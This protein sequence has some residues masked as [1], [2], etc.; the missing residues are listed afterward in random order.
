MSQELSALS[1]GLGY[2]NIQRAHVMQHRFL[3]ICEKE[4][5]N[6]CP[7]ASA[8]NNITPLPAVQRVALAWRSTGVQ[9]FAC[10]LLCLLFLLVASALLPPNAPFEIQIQLLSCFMSSNFFIK[11]YFMIVKRQEIYRHYLLVLIIDSRNH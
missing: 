1:I 3:D 11:L 2:Q 10:P 7:F 4:K 9:S 8:L 6:V 5:K